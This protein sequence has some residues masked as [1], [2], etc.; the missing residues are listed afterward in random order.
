MRQKEL[1]KTHIKKCFFLVLGPL[2]KKPLFSIKGENSPGSCGI[3]LVFMKYDIL[4][5]ME[6]FYT[7]KCVCG[8]FYWLENNIYQQNSAVLAQKLGEKKKIANL[9]FRLF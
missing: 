7:L 6:V 2:S 9:H 4:E 8:Y 5:K 1:G 3:K